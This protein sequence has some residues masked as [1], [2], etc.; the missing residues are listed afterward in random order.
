VIGVRADAQAKGIEL[1][2]LPW[3]MAVIYWQ[4]RDAVPDFHRLDIDISIDRDIP[5]TY[6]LYISPVNSTLNGAGFYGGLQTN[7]NGW[8]SRTDRRR[9]H[10]GKGGI[11]S[12]W[13]EDKMTPIGLDHVDLPVDGLCE[14]AGYE[15]EFCSVRRP[16]AWTKG[17]Y[18][19]SLIKEETVMF[20]NAPHTWVAL[21]IAE[22]GRP[23]TFRIG[24]LLFSGETLALHRNIAAF[25]EIYSTE[26]IRASDVPEATVTLGFPRINGR[27]LPVQ[28]VMTTYPRTGVASSPNVAEVRAEWKN[29]LVRIA[30]VVR[31]SSEDQVYQNIV[32]E[33][34]Y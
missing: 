34:A 7:I 21:E 18:V 27:E 28:G 11:F 33:G 5:E 4:F 19:F 13:S 29:V 3:H 1:P 16:Y 8:M 25:L 14:S 15:G 22:R 6:N 26:K 12:R 31:P 20:R 23:E 10:R 30:P 17:T 32:L 9:V 2:P 24:R